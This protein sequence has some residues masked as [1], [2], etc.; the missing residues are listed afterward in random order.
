MVNVWFALR[1]A[2]SVLDCC[3]TSLR[4]G[5]RVGPSIFNVRQEVKK[6]GLIYSHTDIGSLIKTQLVWS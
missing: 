1:N 2:G 3:A 4:A 5:K 6:I